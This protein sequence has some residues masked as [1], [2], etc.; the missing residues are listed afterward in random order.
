M[1]RSTEEE[2]WRKVQVD[3]DRRRHIFVC[4]LVHLVPSVGRDLN[5]DEQRGTVAWNLCREVWCA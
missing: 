1:N 5:V 4:C 2:S 3:G